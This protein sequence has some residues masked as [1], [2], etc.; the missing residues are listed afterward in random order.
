MKYVVLM[1]AVALGGILLFMNL[2]KTPAPVSQ[3][4]DDS[5]NVPVRDAAWPEVLPVEHASFVLRWGEHVLYNDPV[6]DA[7]WYAAHGAPTAMII[8]HAHP[9]HYDA[10]VLEALVTEGLPL[11]VNPDVYEKLPASL[12]SDSVI[13]LANGETT[14]IG[15]LTI[16][17]V[18]AYNFTEGKTN[19]HPQGVG[20]GYVMERAGVRVYNASDTEDTPE[21]RGQENIDIAFVPMNEPFTMSVEQAAAG[22]IAMQPTQV[23]PYHYRGREGMSDVAEFARLVAEA[24]PAINVQLVEWYP[25]R[26]DEVEEIVE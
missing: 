5:E 13:V 19:F 26:A 25:E 4:V 23:Y 10:A 8:T 3:V 11:V 20:N 14:T 18:P 15:D 6:G 2:S 16:T 9:D 22:V 17:A 7:S 21:F 12:R 24:N 1:G